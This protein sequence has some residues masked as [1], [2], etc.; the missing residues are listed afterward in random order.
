MGIEWFDTTS[1]ASPT[2]DAS[3]DDTILRPGCP[4][5]MGGN[6]AFSI[7]I[8]IQVRRFFGFQSLP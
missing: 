5:G 3:D 8:N 7:V 2:T 4:E 1:V 6:V